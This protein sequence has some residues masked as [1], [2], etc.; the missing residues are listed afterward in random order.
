MDSEVCGLVG[1]RES[2]YC[3]MSLGV[4]RILRREFVKDTMWVPA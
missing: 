1:T 2:C 4:C 3:K